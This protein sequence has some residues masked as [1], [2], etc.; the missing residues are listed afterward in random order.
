[1]WKPRNSMNVLDYFMKQTCL[2][3]TFYSQSLTS[4]PI[5]P[6]LTSSSSST[7]PKPSSS[8]R[9]LFHDSFSKEQR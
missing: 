3:P 7:S 8:K 4:K 5:S 9:H 6:K 1:M 2:S